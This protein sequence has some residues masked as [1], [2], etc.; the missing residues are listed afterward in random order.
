MENREPDYSE[1]KGAST[2]KFGVQNS[3]AID[4]SLLIGY[5]VTPRPDRWYS[6]Q[7]KPRSGVQSTSR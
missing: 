3:G 6:G 7:D 2:L 4:P 1:A 5:G